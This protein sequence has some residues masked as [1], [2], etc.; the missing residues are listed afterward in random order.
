MEDAGERSR[1]DAV[2]HGSDDLLRA[3]IAATSDVIFGMGPDWSEMRFLHGRDFLADSLEP[4]V[5]WIDRYIHADDQ[6]HIRAAI[7]GAIREKRVFELEHR[8]IRA[9][10]TSGWAQTR[11]VPILDAEGHIVEWFG[12]A[13]D[14]TPR[15]EAEEA[16]RASESKYRSLFDSIDEGF[17]IIEMRFDEQGKAVDYVFRETNPAFERQSGLHDPIGKSMRS[18]APAHEEYWFERYGRIVRTGEAERFEDEAAQLDRWFDVYA[19][20]YGDADARQVAVLFS[21]TTARKLTEESLRDAL[22]A[23]DQFLGFISHELRTPM[24]II[25]GASHLLA[26]KLPEGEEREM[27]A[28]IAASSVELSDLIESLLLLVQKPGGPD[29]EP[30][31]P[32]HLGRVLEATLARQRARDPSREYRHRSEGVAFVVSGE[33][34]W[35]ERVLLNLVGNA[36][37]Y[38]PPASPVTVLLEAHADEVRVTVVDEGDGLEPGEIERLFEPFYRGTAHGGTSGAGLGLAV[39]KRIVET[40]GGRIW[41]RPRPSRGAEFGFALPSIATD[42]PF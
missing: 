15:R 10:G 38:S 25:L 9:D 13:T 28:D 19:W 20:R 4:D 30:G 36:A 18:L 12:A 14:V 35:I 26:T 33:E 11:A 8:V 16:I 40:M 2:L 41:A 3:F 21:D 17:C 27:A 23:K 1:V 42:D 37:K 34:A 29:S 32:I 24:T 7:E 5:G 6:A 39:C 22:A 31:P